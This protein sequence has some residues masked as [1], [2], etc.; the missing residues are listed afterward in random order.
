MAF[1]ISVP[2][3]SVVIPTYGK[4]GVGLVRD[5]LQS[6]GQNHMGLNIESVVVDDGSPEEVVTELRSVCDGFNARL[7][8]LDEN[9]GFAKACNAGLREASGMACFLVNNDILFRG[10]PTLQIM[11]NTIFSMNAGVCGTRLLYPDE[12]IQHAGVTFVPAPKDHAIPGWFDHV[13]RHAPANSWDAVIMTN[14]LVTGA[15]MGINRVALNV[16]G[17]LD[18][19]Y[20]MAAEDIDYQLDCV[21]AGLSI[22]YMGYAYAYHLEGKTRGRTIE[23]KLARAPEKWEAEQRGLVEFHKKWYGL[24]WSNFTVMQ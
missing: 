10:C 21:T 11:A 19:R 17:L 14:C 7:I 2:A 22:V 20:G 12:T 6:M 23:E 18:E 5:C 8:H 4:V 15:L 24:N 1:K 9:G 16:I 3:I 13:L